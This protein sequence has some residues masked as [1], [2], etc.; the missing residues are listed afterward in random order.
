MAL[1]RF[2]GN[3]MSCLGIPTPLLNPVL[4]AASSINP[5]AHRCP[6]HPPCITATGPCS[7][8]PLSH[9]QSLHSTLPP[10]RFIARSVH[11]HGS[12]SIPLLML[13]LMDKCPTKLPAGCLK[14]PLLGTCIQQLCHVFPI[15]SVAHVCFFSFFV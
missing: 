9:A 13:L 1:E 6:S 8:C 12:C 7:H 4:F 10:P 11:S 2:T 5:A 15:R 14:R 3:T